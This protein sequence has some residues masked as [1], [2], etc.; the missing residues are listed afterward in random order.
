MWQEEEAKD[1]TVGT[2]VLLDKIHI[3]CI[4]VPEVIS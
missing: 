4:L 3:L 2:R 1:V